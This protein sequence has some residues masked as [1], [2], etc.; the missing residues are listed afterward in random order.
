[1]ST[2]SSSALPAYHAKTSSSAKEYQKL[3]ADSIN[4]L[5]AGSINNLG[6]GSIDNLGAGSINNLG[7]GSI[8]NLGAGSINNLGAGSINNLGASSIDNLGAGSINNLG[9]GSID[10]LSFVNNIYLESHDAPTDPIIGQNYTL[11]AAADLED[12]Q[13]D[14]DEL[15]PPPAKRQRT[16][17]LNAM[18]PWQSASEEIMS[19]W[20]LD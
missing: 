9:A 3:G 19:E 14:I 13:T 15:S 5:G 6:A 7:A 20:T 4:N 11:C 2:A 16:M 12:D 8:D 18:E 10:N 17:T 1:M